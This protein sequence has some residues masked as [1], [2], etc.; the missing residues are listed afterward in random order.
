MKRQILL[1]HALRFGTPVQAHAAAAY[2]PAGDGRPY[3]YQ[4]D[5]ARQFLE[6]G[7]DLLVGRQFWSAIGDDGTYDELL[8]IAQEV[9]T[10][11]DSLVRKALDEA[12]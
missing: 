12:P 6:V 3:R 9:G 4:G 5:Y 1:I 8:D 7:R 11:V 2:N 10:R